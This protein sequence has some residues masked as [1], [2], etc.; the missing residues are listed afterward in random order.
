MLSHLRRSHLVP[1]LLLLAMPGVGGTLVQAGHDCASAAP[2][3]VPAVAAAEHGQ[4]GHGGGATPDERQ[5][6]HQCECV[7]SCNAPAVVAVPVLGPALVVVEPGERRPARTEAVRDIPR[8]R[9]H[10]LLPPA[11]A[12]PQG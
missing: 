12:P 9:P 3:T 7:G 2:W 10:R 11:I 4:H 8:P 5:S 1:I 6:G